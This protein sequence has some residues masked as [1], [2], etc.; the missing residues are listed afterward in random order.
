MVEKDATVRAPV[1]P[2]RTFTIGRLP[3]KERNIYSSS[4]K[5]LYEFME[6][7]PGLSIPNE[8]YKITPEFV[9]ES[10]EK[11]TEFLK[12][13]VSYVWNLKNRDIENWTISTWSKQVSHGFIQKYGTDSDKQKLPPP[14]YKCGPRNKRQKR[15]PVC[16]L[17]AGG[18]NTAISEDIEKHTTCSHGFRSG[19]TPDALS[20]SRVPANEE[21]KRKR[22]VEGNACSVTAREVFT[23]PA[24][25]PAPTLEE[26]KI[27]E[28]E[29]VRT[30]ER[31]KQKQTKKT[32]RQSSKS[33]NNT[34]SIFEIAF[35]D[36]PKQHI[37][38]AAAEVFKGRTVA[39]Q[40]RED[41]S[42][43]L[44][45]AMP[46]NNCEIP[47]ASIEPTAFCNAVDTILE[48]AG[49][50]AERTTE[51]KQELLT[52]DFEKERWKS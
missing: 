33:K 34:D 46:F 43:F 28:S 37:D 9:E 27:Q 24:P 6:K 31:T 14:T 25:A 10:F 30:N 48:A 20:Y 11:A 52:T 17:P 4:W 44:E 41:G 12:E 18:N 47:T 50:S 15:T 38:S 35:G 29:V 21:G 22:Q 5:P 36:N 40:N 1:R 2:Y 3:L 49:I 32:R 39:V 19:Q 45:H 26:E 16:L 23:R 8:V 51:Q 7:C 13:R 42:S